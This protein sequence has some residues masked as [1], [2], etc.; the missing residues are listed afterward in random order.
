L[1]AIIWK[2]TSAIAEDRTIQ[3]EFMEE[4]ARYE[5]VYHR[6]SKDFK[7]KNKKAN[8]WK[9]IGEKFNLSAADAEVKFRNIRT[10]YGR[11]LKRLKTLPSG[12]GRDA[13]P[14]EF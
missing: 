5:C 14:R 8:C 10:A 6:N 3:E 1:S 11:S 4:V 2:H 12:S 7:D 13:V 9:K